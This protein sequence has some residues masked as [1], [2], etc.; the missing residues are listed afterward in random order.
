MSSSAYR[1]ILRMWEAKLREAEITF[2]KSMAM[3]AK[4]RMGRPYF[5]QWIALIELHVVQSM[6]AIEFGDRL[7]HTQ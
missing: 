7:M 3:H 4:I 5:E 6:D 1:S 2:A